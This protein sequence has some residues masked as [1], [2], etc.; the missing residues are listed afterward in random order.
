[1]KSLIIEP[2]LVSSFT[3]ASKKSESTGTN[4]KSNASFSVCTQPSLNS[5]DR[6][7]FPATREEIGWPLL[8]PGPSAA[9][10]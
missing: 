8:A 3:R 6:D 1:M 2:R 4:S 5:N 7:Q 9:A 10:D